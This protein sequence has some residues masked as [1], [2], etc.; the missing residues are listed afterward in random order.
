MKNI[1]VIFGLLAGIMATHIV[2]AK[3][4][5]E[6]MEKVQVL[7]YEQELELLADYLPETAVSFRGEELQIE[8]YDSNFNLLKEGIGYELE[9]I[10]DKELD[11]LV[12]K[13][14]Y[15]AQVGSRKIYIVQ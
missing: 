9:E 13:S 11:V 7:S 1:V 12:D 5:K 2:H 15:I 6:S 10:S 3:G 8:V 14:D 4:K